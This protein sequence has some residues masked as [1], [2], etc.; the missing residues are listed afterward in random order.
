MPVDRVLVVADHDERRAPGA[1]LASTWMLHR[2]AGIA[3]EDPQRG[4]RH[5]RP[6]AMAPLPQRFPLLDDVGIDANRGIVDEDAIV[7][8][9]DVDRLDVPAAIT[10]TASRRSSGI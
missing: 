8:R 4:D 5:R 3:P 10:A 7:H 1:D 9:A 6:L 2:H